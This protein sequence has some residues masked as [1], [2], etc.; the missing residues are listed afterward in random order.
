MIN[1]FC[2]LGLRAGTHEDECKLMLL[3][4]INL[5]PL[6]IRKTVS[7]MMEVNAIPAPATISRSSLY[8]DVAFMKFMG[9]EHERMTKADTVLYG[10]TD[11][12]ELKGLPRESRGL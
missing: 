3:R 12:T 7:E 4:A 1:V 11:S 8:L 2:L 6:Q 5:F 10:L 9:M